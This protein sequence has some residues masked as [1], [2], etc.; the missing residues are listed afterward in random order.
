MLS[1]TI[2]IYPKTTSRGFVTVDFLVSLI[3]SFG[4]CILFFV[5][6][7]TLTAVE[8]AQY[9]AFSTARAM[10]SADVDPEQQI[11][12]ARNKYK[13]LLT[14]ASKKGVGGLFNKNSGWFALSEPGKLEIRGG[15]AAG[16]DFGE[17]YSAEAGADGSG[18]SG[19]PFIGVRLEFTARLLSMKVPFLG[20]TNENKDGF[21]TNITGFLMREPT[22][23]ECDQFFK[24]R[25]Q[26]IRNLDSARWPGNTQSWDANPLTV[27]D[28]AC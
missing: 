28:N 3:L 7:L 8:V 18:I 26:Q 9:I 15:D 22:H 2:S 10:S 24:D 23:A 12:N 1:K 27:E 17:D 19:I 11:L 16:G 25:P 5:F 21:K 6:S 13:S 20:H 4:V 14:D